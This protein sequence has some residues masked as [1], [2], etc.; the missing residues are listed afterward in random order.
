MED[1]RNSLEGLLEEAIRWLSLVMPTVDQLSK[2][3]LLHSVRVGVYLYI[4]G[5]PKEICLAGLLHDAIEDT[6]ITE[7]AIEQRFGKVVSA[8]VI[9]NTKNERLR[10]KYEKY[11]DLMDCCVR[12]GE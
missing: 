12:A 1:S 8:L 6:P 9:A 10:D 2:P 7:E 4:R 11:R 5:Y 3:T